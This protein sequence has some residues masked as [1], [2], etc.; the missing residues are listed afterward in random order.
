[1]AASNQVPEKFKALL[2]EIKTDKGSE[3]KLAEMVSV[4]KCGFEK[5]SIEKL[6]KS[7]L[8][9][10]YQAFEEMSWDMVEAQNRINGIQHRIDTALNIFRK[11]EPYLTSTPE[12]QNSNMEPLDDDEVTGGKGNK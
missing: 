3:A 11:I 8:S 7:D 1:M 4:A 10:I 6:S 2:D 5:L 9:T 12:C